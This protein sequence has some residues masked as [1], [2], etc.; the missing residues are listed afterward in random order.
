MRRRSLFA[1]AALF[2]LTGAACQLPTPASLRPTPTPNLAFTQAAEQVVQV[3]TQS[4]YTSTPTQTLP[5]DTPAPTATPAA[6]NTPTAAPTQGTDEAGGAATA[7][8]AGAPA[9]QVTAEPGL[10]LVS[11]PEIKGYVFQVDSSRW[12]AG[13]GDQASDLVNRKLSGCRIDWV[14]GHGLGSP[15]RL[16][17][18]DLG[19]FRWLIY[20]YGSSALAAPYASA[21]GSASS[22]ATGS[23]FLE[24]VGYQQSA[25]RSD[26]EEVLASLITAQEASGGARFV[27]YPSPT[28]RPALEGFS[29]PNTPPVRL[30]V[31]DQ[32]AV[33]TDGLWLR[34]EPRADDSTKVRKYLRNAPVFVR[35][36]GGPV[37][38]KFV[39]WQV[40][41]STI[42]EPSESI[43][44]WFGEGDP[45]EYYLKPVN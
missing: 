1:F 21:Y 43:Q 17:W 36:I 13:S 32:A 3:I 45:S 5:T 40:E 24:L 33:I 20:D 12:A 6:T 9:F 28:P 23:E 37:C 35:I 11:L 41:I 7:T 22:S 18:T 8:P 34:S 30:R 26:Q 19:R 42:G 14:P 15:Q 39:Y 31:G 29:C 4:A 44:G 16:L 25:C 10:A 27:P 38:E 2:I